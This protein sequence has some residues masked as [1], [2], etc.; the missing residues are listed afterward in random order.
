M[1][2]INMNNFSYKI[3]RE[4]KNIKVSVFGLSLDD[5]K[6]K[7]V[8]F[9][10]DINTEELK[11]VISDIFDIIGQKSGKLIFLPITLIKGGIVVSGIEISLDKDVVDIVEM[12]INIIATEVEKAF[13]N[14]GSINLSIR[15]VLLSLDSIKKDINNYTAEVVSS[16]ANMFIPKSIYDR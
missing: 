7:E 5:N 11:N 8:S 2:N 9:R 14:Q 12:C 6:N 3:E 10:N 1:S 4:E 16:A 15:D 13:V